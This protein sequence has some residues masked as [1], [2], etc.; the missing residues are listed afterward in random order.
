[1]L[2]PQFTIN[3]HNTLISCM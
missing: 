1:M 3:K 2:G